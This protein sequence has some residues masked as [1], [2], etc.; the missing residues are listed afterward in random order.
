M[1]VLHSVWEREVPS[2]ELGEEGGGWVGR[3]EE[4]EAFVV[5]GD[6]TTIAVHAHMY[7]WCVCVCVCVNG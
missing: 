6:F 2:F 3:E 4:G 5:L 7:M 1:C